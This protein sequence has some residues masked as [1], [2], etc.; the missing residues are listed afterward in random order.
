MMTQDWEAA[1]FGNRWAVFCKVNRAYIFIGKGK[2]F[3]ERKAREL[4][5]QQ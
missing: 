4:N 2:R 5:S 1:K 3:C